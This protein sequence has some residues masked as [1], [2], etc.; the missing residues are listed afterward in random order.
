MRSFNW[1]EAQ[2]RFPARIW[3]PWHL[4][5]AAAPQPKKVD[6]LVPVERLPGAGS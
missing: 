2:Y 3:Y 6:R 5:L 4:S 1:L